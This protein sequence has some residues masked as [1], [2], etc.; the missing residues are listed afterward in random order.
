MKSPGKWSDAKDLWAVCWRMLLIG[1]LV[2]LFGTLV[3]TAV[4]ALTFA[5]PALAIVW[6]LDGQYLW[7]FLAAALSLLWLRF[8]SPI[9]RFVFEGFEH[10]SL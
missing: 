9:R 8:G 6:I 2:G 4:L 3:L 5:P 10:G 7:A 1:P